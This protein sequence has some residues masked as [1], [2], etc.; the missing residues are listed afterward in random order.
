MIV[1]GFHRAKALGMLGGGGSGSVVVCCGIVVGE[2]GREEVEC[3]VLYLLRSLGIAY[4]KETLLG[5]GMKSN[6]SILRA[7]RYYDSEW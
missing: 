2:G 7:L 1:V 4:G 3:S 5:N 6:L